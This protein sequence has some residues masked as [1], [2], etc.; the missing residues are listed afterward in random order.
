MHHT[1][2]VE[3]GPIL[4]TSHVFEPGNVNVASAAPACTATFSAVAV[5]QIPF[6][7]QDQGASWLASDDKKYNGYAVQA[8]YS[9]ATDLACLPSL[10]GRAVRDCYRVD[11]FSEEWC[12][13]AA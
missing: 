6:T 12:C 7:S 2:V 3:L 8:L 5:E 13:G 4:T 9:V 1:L 11:F 10:R